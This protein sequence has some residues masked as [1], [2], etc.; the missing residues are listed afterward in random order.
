M[1]VMGILRTAATAAVAAS[2]CAAGGGN[3]APAREGETETGRWFHLGPG[4]VTRTF[5]VRRPEGIVRLTRITTTSG[6]RASVEATVRGIIAVSVSSDQGLFDPARTCH[7]QGKL[8]I[9]TQ[10]Q[11]GCPAPA[12]VWDV[13]LEKFGGPAGLVRF[14]FVVS[15]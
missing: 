5:K 3:A 11:E 12:A 2:L 6:I 15:A 1:C 8:Q 10:A 7:R 14:D 4:S 9:C 13:R